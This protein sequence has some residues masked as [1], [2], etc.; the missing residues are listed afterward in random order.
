MPP[1]GSKMLHT[2]C[3]ERTVLRIEFIYI[4]P[5]VSSP[6]PV[7]AHTKGSQV[8]LTPGMCHPVLWLEKQVPHLR[9]GCV[10]GASHL[11][12]VLDGSTQRVW[13]WSGRLTVGGDPRQE[14][15]MALETRDTHR[16]F[17]NSVFLFS[18]LH[19]DYFFSFS[20]LLI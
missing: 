1:Q 2:G 20:P 7:S 15:L 16:H 4:L 6:P 13:G 3:L 9:C 5:P 14:C 8:P 10:T 17:L 11:P 12:V 19:L 18:C